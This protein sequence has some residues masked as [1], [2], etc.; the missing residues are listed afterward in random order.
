MIITSEICTIH[1][2][3]GL[4]YPAVI[5]SRVGHKFTLNKDSGSIIMNNKFGVGLKG[6]DS[7][8]R[9]L[10]ETVI[11]SASKLDN[12]MS[13]VNELIRLLYVAMTRAK[14]KLSI[15]GT[16]EISSYA[17]NK[18]KGIYYSSSFF[19]MLFKGIDNSY[20]SHFMNS[21]KFVIN[22]DTPSE[23]VVNIYKAEDLVEELPDNE[24]PIILDKGVEGLISSLTEMHNKAPNYSPK[25]IKNSVT[26]ILKDE[27]DYENLNFVPKKLDATDSVPSVDVLK[28]GTAYHT[29]MQNIDFTE[30]EAEIESLISRLVASGD[31]DFELSKNIKPKEIVKA[32]E[33][34]A[35]YLENATAIYKEKQFLLCENYNKLVDFT[36]NNTKVIVQGVI[37]FVVVKG[38]EVYLI[39]YK[40]NRGITPE[41]LVEEYKLQLSLYQK[42]FEEVTKLKVTRKY[43][44]SFYLGEL[45]EVI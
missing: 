28:L 40:A 18:R 25:T 9:T 29:I 30:K 16:Y 6:I 5:L 8:N 23:A 37:D 44:Y 35:P 14:E 7:N 21:K 4:E 41:I 33:V 26:S 34:I 13:Q 31:I 45:I 19:D 43:L 32:I 42:A 24:N 15:I 11:R 17:E 20:N 38:E 12:K 22:Q 39:D 36:D 1:H 27:S 2:S 3:K 10:D